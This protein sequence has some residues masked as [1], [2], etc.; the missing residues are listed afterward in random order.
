MGKPPKLT[1]QQ[2][3]Y[4][5]L[6]EC[7]GNARGQRV[8]EV[9][10]GTGELSQKLAIDGALPM[11]LDLTEPEALTHPAAAS[12]FLYSET[13][14][15]GRWRIGDTSDRELIDVFCRTHS[16]LIPAVTVLAIAPAVYQV[17]VVQVFDLPN[18]DG[19]DLSLLGING[20]VWDDISARLR[21][22]APPRTEDPFAS[23]A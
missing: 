19:P 2:F 11:A 21:D 18:M 14:G 17:R 1:I 9:G 10:A 7:L 13:D 5:T 22:P 20:P 16:D 4:E 12:T 8:L 15:H 3:A 23:G 6:R